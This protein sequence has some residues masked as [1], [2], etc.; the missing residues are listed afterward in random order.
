MTL[1]R[2]VLNGGGRHTCNDVRAAGRAA[3][4]EGRQFVSA[5]LN[6]ISSLERRV[7]PSQDASLLSLFLRYARES[8]YVEDARKGENEEKAY[9]ETE[10]K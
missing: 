9:E 5:Q 4:L 1:N 2:N 6:C 8:R 7:L 10:K 3:K